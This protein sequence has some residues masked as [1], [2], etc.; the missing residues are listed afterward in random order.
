M[1]EDDDCALI[2]QVVAR[3]PFLQQV[4]IREADKWEALEEK[5][6]RYHEE[7]QKRLT[8]GK[9]GRG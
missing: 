4:C 1:T 3:S 2:A 5:R 6:R 7:R 8:E 9:R